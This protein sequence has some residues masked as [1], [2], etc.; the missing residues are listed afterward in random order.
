MNNN[1]ST[2]P[3][4]GVV[5]F[6]LII[7]WPVGLF[8]LGKKVSNN[9][10]SGIKGSGLTV[11]GWIFVVVGVFYIYLWLTDNMNIGDASMAQTM[12]LVIVTFFGGGFLMIHIGRKRMRRSMAT[13]FDTVDL[14]E[15]HNNM[16]RY[17][18]PVHNTCIHQTIIHSTSENVTSN[19]V[20]PK[21]E[22]AEPTIKI[23][24][25]KNCGANNRVSSD[26]VTEC[27]F[28]GSLISG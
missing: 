3:S 6:V 11:F 15:I 27:E 19:N 22:K 2:S 25:C 12:V 16:G 10:A 23:L 26:Q 13:S 5:I 7:F 1:K 21:V 24:A 9:K 8:L 4:W 14:E 18:I 20:E 28:C 17:E